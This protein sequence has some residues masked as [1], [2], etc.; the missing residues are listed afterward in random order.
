MERPWLTQ[1]E[2]GVPATLS[3]PDVPLHQ[4]LSNSARRFPDRAALEFYGRR[5]SYR[6]LDALTDRFAQALLRLGV[7]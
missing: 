1:Y 5:I 4:L 6:Q 7:R 2:A 3:Y